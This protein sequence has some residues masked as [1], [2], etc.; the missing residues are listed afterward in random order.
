[1]SNK[2]ELAEDLAGALVA[3]FVGCIIFIVIIVNIPGTTEIDGALI[4]NVFTGGVTLFAP[5][6]AYYLLTDWKEQ[7]NLKI[8]S[9]DAQN[10]WKMSKNERLIWRDH[11]N[12]LN[13]Y[14]KN[15]YYLNDCTSFNN[16][17]QRSK[18]ESQKVNRDLYQF[19]ELTRDKELKVLVDKKISYILKYEEEYKNNLLRT[20][21]KFQSKITENIVN[22]THHMKYI[23]DYLQE[24]YILFY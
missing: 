6:A 14:Q 23:E 13:Q 19:I 8:F 2:K 11:Y 7:H 18:S 4:A 22:I 10:I 1:M 9:E 15:A 16:L 21:H 5:I 17:F 20:H 24:K 3:I 12:G